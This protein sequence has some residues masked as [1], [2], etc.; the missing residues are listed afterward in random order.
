MKSVNINDIDISVENT[1][2]YTTDDRQIFE[3]TIELAGEQYREADLRSGRGGEPSELRMLETLL[4]FLAAAGES[5]RYNGMEGES[6]SLF[7]EPVTKW[8]AENADAIS[9]EQSNLEEAIGRAAKARE[10]AYS[11]HGGQESALYAFASSGI[12]ENKEGLLREVRRCLAQDED[13][14]EEAELLALMDFVE[15]DLEFDVD[16]HTGINQW[17]A[18]WH[19]E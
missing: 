14:D 16:L 17:L 4:A 6:S 7:P 2:R 11:W 3:W 19:D 18:P 12:C 1:D 13:E 9:M 5:Y 10:T 8:A 15:N